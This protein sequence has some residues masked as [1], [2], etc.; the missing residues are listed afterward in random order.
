MKEKTAVYITATAQ[1]F[2]IMRNMNED[3]AKRFPL[4]DKTECIGFLQRALAQVKI[5]YGIY[6]AETKLEALRLAFAAAA[7]GKY[8]GVNDGKLRWRSLARDL[9]Y[10]AFRT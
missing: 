5:R 1:M 8:A 4:Y 6:S 2:D 3:V 10:V 9:Q 7:S